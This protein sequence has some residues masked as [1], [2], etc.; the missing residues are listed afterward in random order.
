MTEFLGNNEMNRRK[1]RQV[2]SRH[3][4]IQSMDVL[5]RRSLLTS[6]IPAI[7]IDNQAPDFLGEVNGSAVLFV[8]DSGTTTLYLS[9][10]TQGG[11]TS[12]ATVT[13]IIQTE[14]TVE[15]VG[16]N[17]FFVATGAEGS[18]L[19]KTDGTTDGTGLVVD[20]NAGSADSSPT[21]LTAFND[22]L[23]FAATTAEEGRELYMSDG[24]AEG[25]TL[26]TSAIAGTDGHGPKELFV[27]DDVLFYSSTATLGLHRSD[28]S[29]IVESTFPAIPEGSRFSDI[30]SYVVGEVN[31]RLLVHRTIGGEF[32]PQRELLSYESASDTNPD[33]L[34]SFGLGDRTYAGFTRYRNSG[35]RLIFE[36][37]WFF[38]ENAHKPPWNHLWETDGTIAGTHEIDFY[39]GRFT[40]V[41]EELPGEFRDNTIFTTVDD[42]WAQ[43]GSPDDFF[44]SIPANIGSARTSTDTYFLD[45]SEG[46]Y[47]IRKVNDDNSGLQL[48]YSTTT[49]I[50]Q[51]VTILGELYFTV[52]S[53]NET[54]LWK[55]DES[56]QLPAGPTITSPNVGANVDGFN[57]AF[58]W[59]TLA[60]AV[61]YDV[62]VTQTADGTE[63]AVAS[64]QRVTPTSV[65]LGVPPGQ[66]L[67]SIRARFADG[68]V[69]DWSRRFVSSSV[70]APT[71]T[72]PDGVVSDPDP[73]IEWTPTDGAASY[74]VWI[75][76]DGRYKIA[77]NVSASSTRTSDLLHNGNTDSYQDGSTVRIWVRAVFANGTKTS[78]SAGRD[79]VKSSDG[80]HPAIRPFQTSNRDDLNRPEFAWASENNV[81]R[82]ELYI[83]KVGDRGTAVYQRT[84]LSES[85]HQLETRL[86]HGQYEVW[87]RI[88][89]NDGSRTRWGQTPHLHTI[90]VAR[91]EITLAEHDP[92]TNRLNLEWNS[93]DIDVTFEIW[94]ASS[95]NQQVQ[96][97]NVKDLT[98]NSYSQTLEIDERHR[99][100]VR[101]SHPVN[102]LS[103]WSRV[104]DIESPEFPRPS[105]VR[106]TTGE[107]DTTPGLDWDAVPNATSYELY[108]QRPYDSPY[109]RT[110]QTNQ[111]DV[112]VE[113]RS[114]YQFKAWVRAKF[115]NNQSTRWSDVTTFSIS[116]AFSDTVPEFS[117]SGNRA[118]W[119]AVAGANRYELWVNQVDANGRTTV[120]RIRHETSL[121][122]DGYD[123]NLAAGSYRGWL[124]AFASS[125][126]ISKWGVL[127]FTIVASEPT[128]PSATPNLDSL[129]TVAVP[130]KSITDRHKVDTSSP[131]SFPVFERAQGSK[132]ATD[133]PVVDTIEIENEA[134]Q[135]SIET[136]DLVF[137]DS[138][139][140]DFILINS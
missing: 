109:Q 61:N 93:T 119:D 46:Q 57:V 42:K 137:T 110:L 134:D 52:Q 91:P 106:I 128:A 24:T 19:W 112:E 136:M 130:V 43:N 59:N 95:A 3:A 121:S 17:L 41:L 39:S 26:T 122:D 8:E 69:T 99:A 60:G 4:I 35:E 48:I 21:E 44:Y 140:T 76:E 118:S 14:V 67:V 9:D 23:Y 97:I 72:S 80:L 86:P 81:D 94:V 32:T 138:A 13:A 2:N 66:S 83:N 92:V 15:T 51:P 126:G 7:Q 12:F 62:L 104:A 16:T 1:N 87:V 123:L 38:A 34:L 18:E 10:G 98:T 111:H 133:N 88:F 135:I 33:L 30:G 5:E 49:A 54:S 64:A 11:T 100:W 89:F 22:K 79:W 120:T 25:T 84:D 102:G 108:I 28:S 55:I 116:D 47:S 31:G 56:A 27:Y 103:A 127:E 74:D 129:L 75:A 114:G 36:Q 37:T 131:Q 58:S 85:Q 20:L 73:L 45:Q 90:E 124:R 115:S 6:A 71:V 77:G 70:A 117:V 68:S 82:Y 29:D 101:A 105:E 132:D 40:P 53:G 125:G 65:T 107:D 78:W 139:L 113:L 50:S 96:V 63:T